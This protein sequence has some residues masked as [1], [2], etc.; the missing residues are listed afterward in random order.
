VQ[1]YEFIKDE[2][3]VY[4]I[5]YEAIKQSNIKSLIGCSN[6]VELVYTIYQMKIKSGK[7]LINQSCNGCQILLA[8]F[9]SETEILI[10]RKI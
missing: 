7:T 2:K 6:F 8:V 5:N 3:Y 10:S 1:L 4:N 9:E